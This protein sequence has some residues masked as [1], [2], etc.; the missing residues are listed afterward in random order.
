M[1]G[2]IAF[3]EGLRRSED[4]SNDDKVYCEFTHLVNR[5]KLTFPPDDLVIFSNMTDLFFKH[6]QQT[7]G[8]HTKNAFLFLYDS[9][10][11]SFDKTSSVCQRLTNCFFKGL[12][13]KE[14]DILTAEN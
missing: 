9:F 12:V 7:C 11:F 13:R 10:N 6:T 8:N 5:G 4:S 1:C 14:M 2:Y 3:K